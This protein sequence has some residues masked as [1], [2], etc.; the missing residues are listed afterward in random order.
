MLFENVCGKKKIKIK[1]PK[2]PPNNQIKFYVHDHTFRKKKKPI[3]NNK[4]TQINISDAFI[5]LENKIHNVKMKEVLLCNVIIKRSV[6]RQCN[7]KK[8]VV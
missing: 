7:D 6:M 4:I 5:K 3:K 1:K 2:I 8:G